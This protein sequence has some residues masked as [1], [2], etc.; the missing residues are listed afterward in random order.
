M[1]E[2]YFS[3]HLLGQDKKYIL[4]KEHE[5]YNTWKQMVNKNYELYLTLF[6]K[7]TLIDFESK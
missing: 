6:K 5:S 4:K 3:N 2:I 7:E 1:L